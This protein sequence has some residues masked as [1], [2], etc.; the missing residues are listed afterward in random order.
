MVV[1]LSVSPLPQPNNRSKIAY[2][3][4]CIVILIP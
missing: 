1:S 4:R 2:T 3:R